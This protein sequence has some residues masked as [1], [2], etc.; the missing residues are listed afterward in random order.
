[1]EDQGALSIRSTKDVSEIPV[2]KDMALPNLSTRL[3]SP[4]IAEKMSLS[5]VLLFAIEM[6][7][8]AAFADPGN[9]SSAS[10]RAKA[11]GMNS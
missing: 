11:A 1:V 9:F 6:A 5:P 2:L 7:D 3:M 10:G 4:D 8:S